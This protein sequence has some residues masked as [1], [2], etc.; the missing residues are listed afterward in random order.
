ML[1]QYTTHVWSATEY[2]NGALILA[3]PTQLQR[4]DKM[5]RCFLHEL[6]MTDTGAFVV[7]NFAP[8]FFLSMRYRTQVCS[9]LALAGKRLSH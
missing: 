5:Q 8:P 4:I 3:L 2:H 1:S 9:R 7:Y 6:D